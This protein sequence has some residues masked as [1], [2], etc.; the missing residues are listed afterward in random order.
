MSDSLNRPSVNEKEHLG[1]AESQSLAPSVETAVIYSLP[2]KGQEG[3]ASFAER[4]K[5]KQKQS[6]AYGSL[7]ELVPRDMRGI[8]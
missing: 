7:N 4:K 5:N 3:Q 2:R 8:L 1:R 6:A